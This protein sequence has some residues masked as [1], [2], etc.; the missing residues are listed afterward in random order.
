MLNG[1]LEKLEHL[2]QG[3][4]QEF[5]T[6]LGKFFFVGCVRAVFQ[7]VM[8]VCF[9]IS[10]KNNVCVHVYAQRPAKGKSVTQSSPNNWDDPPKYE[11]PVSTPCPV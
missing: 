5:G 8:Y 6:I 7:C 10:F 3:I 4:T 9:V 11:P 2:Q 1:A